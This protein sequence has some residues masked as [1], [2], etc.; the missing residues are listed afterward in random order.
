MVGSSAVI[1]AV[2]IKIGAVLAGKYRVERILARGGM[3]IVVQAWHLQLHQAVAVKLIA[4][5]ALSDARNVQRF[6][7]EARA[8]VRLKSEHIARVLDVGSLDSGAPYIVLEYLDGT[9]LASF[10]RSELTVGRIVDL[11]LQA[12]EALAEVHALDIVHRDVKPGNLFITRSAVGALH[13][14]LLDFGISKIPRKSELTATQTLMG[15][16]AYSSPEQLRSSRQV[17]HRSDIW[18][19]G[20]VL[21]ELLQGAVPYDGDT[22]AAMVLQI[23][24]DPLPAMTVSLPDGLAQIVCRCLEKEPAQR[25]QTMAELAE[26]L[27]PHAH[28]ATQATLSVQRTRAM[29]ADDAPA[30]LQASPQLAAALTATLADS[31]HAS[32]AAA[33]PGAPPPSR[34]RRVWSTV[35][36]VCVML[37]VLGFFVTSD[38]PRVPRY[39]GSSADSQLSPPSPPLM[40]PPSPQP[41]PPSEPARTTQPVAASPPSR[42]AL[43]AK[44]AA[45]TH[46][47][48][49]PDGGPSTTPG[50]SLPQIDTEPPPPIDTP[51][52]GPEPQPSEAK[53]HKISSPEDADDAEDKEILKDDN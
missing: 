51:T 21:H 50:S 22:F 30:R 45:R 46:R 25:F 26:A 7:W 4:P 36:A 31:A 3:G 41:Q 43:G 38:G 27:A 10:P 14:K 44:R 39:P 42:D 33:A 17:D 34:R 19:L 6:L 32:N 15:T 8:A 29:A 20:V 9:D 18:S 1:D 47:R 24:N 37:A 48:T 13:L 40:I 2:G 11:V 49:P 53:P 35:A 23:A 5:T 52:T 28:S 16:P 12:C